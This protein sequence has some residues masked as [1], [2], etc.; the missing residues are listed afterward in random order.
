MVAV[1]SSRNYTASSQSTP[2]MTFDGHRSELSGER[3]MVTPV[4]RSHNGGVILNEVRDPSSRQEAV[5]PVR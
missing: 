4:A 2:R 5:T 3:A 1:I